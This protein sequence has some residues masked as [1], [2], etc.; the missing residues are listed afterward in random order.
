MENE[1]CDFVVNN[2]LLYSFC[3]F[4]LSVAQI[5]RKRKRYAVDPCLGFYATPEPPVKTE[6]ASNA[7]PTSPDL[8]PKVEE[9]IPSPIASPTLEQQVTVH[10]FLT[11]TAAKTWAKRY[12]S[13]RR[14]RDMEYAPSP[15]KAQRRGSKKGVGQRLLQ[16]AVATGVEPSDSFMQD[17]VDASV[18]RR[19]LQFQVAADDGKSSSRRQ[20]SLVDPKKTTP[21]HRGT[22]F[23]PK[24]IR[25]DADGPARVKPR[26]PL[27]QWH[28]INHRSPAKEPLARSKSRVKF[29]QCPPLSFIPLHAA[30]ESYSRNK[31]QPRSRPTRLLPE[32]DRESLAFVEEPLPPKHLPAQPAGDICILDEPQQ[33]NPETPLPEILFLH[34]L[35]ADIQ[36]PCSSSSISSQPLTS[37][38]ASTSNISSAPPIATDNNTQ[39]MRPLASFLESFL[40]TVRTATQMQ[41]SQN[42]SRPSTSARGT[43]PR[44][45]PRTAALTQQRL[46]FNSAAPDDSRAYANGSFVH[47]VFSHELDLEGGDVD[48]LNDAPVTKNLADVLSLS[49]YQVVL[50]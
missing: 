23:A 46:D 42:L 10:D 13:K 39:A 38:D 47:D 2:I 11:T 41:E 22:S 12:R 16:A 31:D 3:T 49:Q 48:F 29:L 21:F 44:P 35:Q 7:L 33:I 9:R 28:T 40:E 19:P 24:T 6:P 34:N 27:T 25:S 32:V 43:R 26:Q 15:E 4:D 8:C 5:R 30:E 14:A 36:N 17:I 50:K 18:T 1:G 37:D 45:R 20:W